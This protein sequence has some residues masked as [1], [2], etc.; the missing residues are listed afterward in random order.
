[1]AFADLPPGVHAEH[2]NNH[3]WWRPGWH[4]GRQAYTWHITF[5]G[6]SDLHRL[7]AEY[8]RAMGNLPAAEPIPSEWLHMTLQ[9]VGFTDEV[10]PGELEKILASVQRHLGDTDPI[11]LT[12]G[13]ATVADEAVVIAPHEGSAI[14]NL[15]AEIREAIGAVMG[16]D[17]VQEDANRFRPHVSAAYIAEEGASAPYIAAVESI[18]PAPAEVTVRGA[19][20]IAIN[21]DDRMYKWRTCAVAPLGA[22]LA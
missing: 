19:S 14:T 6:A 9:G 2:V 16:A 13:A 8:Q 10:E 12:F 20:L 3:W 18:D 17:N 7:I 15:R 4:L 21:R 11:R 5:E 22:G 1:V